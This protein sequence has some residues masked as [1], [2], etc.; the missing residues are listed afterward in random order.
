MPVLLSIGEFARLTHLSVK[1]LRHYD[2]VR[3]LAPADVD[4]SSGYRLYSTAQVPTAQLIR[5]FRDLEMP[6][7]HIRAVLGSTDGVER[8]RLIA[9]H[10]R[11]MESKLDR[12]RATVAS[13]RDLLEGRDSGSGLVVER[14]RLP[15]VPALAVSRTVGWDDIGGWLGDAFARLEARLASEDLER[16]GDGGALYSDAFFQAHEGEVVAFVPVAAGTAPAT[17][18]TAGAR[19]RV[20]L[21]VLPAVDVAASVHTG[22]FTE[23]DATYGALGTWVGER[24]LGAG[25]PIREH[26]LDPAASGAMRV[27]VCW[28]IRDDRAAAGED[29]RPPR[30]GAGP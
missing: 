7:D 1:A 8:D 16:R 23:I 6:L 19:D 17:P 12:T 27:E 11:H 9:E 28:P 14:R 2:E 21:V 24:A 3:L 15:A 22:P 20:E 30:Y 29:V 25:G 26:Y 4:P 10:L 5:R 13:L 18:W